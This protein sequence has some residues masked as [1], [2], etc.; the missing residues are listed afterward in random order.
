MRVVG[1]AMAL[2][3]V[4]LFLAVV[5]SLHLLQPGYDPSA[6]LMS[7]LALGPHGW[8]M[9][10]A[11][12]ALAMAT[13]GIQVAIG[14]FGASVGLRLV[15]LAAAASFL[16]AG[17][18]PLG[19]T[20]LIHIAAIAMAFVLFVLAMYLFPSQAGRASLLVPRLLTWGLGAAVGASVAL[21]HSVLPMG[22]AQRAAAFFVLAWLVIVGWR[23]C[24]Q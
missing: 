18:F 17:I 1:G 22:L 21:G 23:L 2:A 6:Q 14:P 19:E 7:E 13:I 24:R 11:F 15:L 10:V 4:G 20:A 3:G 5:V 8:A 16:A 12:V 9:L